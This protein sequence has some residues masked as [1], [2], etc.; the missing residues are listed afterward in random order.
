MFKMSDKEGS[1]Q[2][3]MALPIIEETTPSPE[4]ADPP[5]KNLMDVMEIPELM[6][7][8]TDST[9]RPVK[10]QSSTCD[11]QRNVANGNFLVFEI[12]KKVTE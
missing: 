2:F 3:E 8:G 10:I 5:K 4:K 6:K 12:S 7:N 1:S 11:A 9:I